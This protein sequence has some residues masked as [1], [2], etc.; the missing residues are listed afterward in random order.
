MTQSFTLGSTFKTW[1]LVAAIAGI[2]SACQ[3]QEENTGNNVSLNT[4]VSTESAITNEEGDQPT[5]EQQL[6]SI[7]AILEAQDD[8]LKS[9]YSA[10]KPKETL[11]F[12]GIKPGMTVVEVL[13]GDG[14]Y[15]KILVPYLGSEGKL[16]AVDYPYEIWHHFN[17]ASRDFISDRKNWAAGWQVKANEWYA[18]NAAPVVAYPFDSIPEEE[19][20]TADAVL[21]IRALH[22][23]NRFEDRGQFFT[24]SLQRTNELLKE[25]GL[26]CVVQHEAPEDKSLTWAD[27][28]RGYLNKADLIKKIE[29]MGFSFVKESDLHH[30]EL[31]QPGEDDSVWRLPPALSTSQEDEALQEKMKAIGESNR[32]TLV[33]Q[34]K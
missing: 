13:P 19:N 16:I 12:F 29:S 4:V 34:K 15:S 9:R 23:L 11:E 3:K 25:G 31:D 14:W 22:N 8:E 20:A 27:G 26:L 28:S 18:E 7:D 30:N 21:F 32:M 24:S 17:W 33:F 6:P 1:C 10:R 2:C 5:V